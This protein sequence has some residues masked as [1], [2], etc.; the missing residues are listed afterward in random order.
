MTTSSARTRKPLLEDQRKLEW[1]IDACMPAVIF[2]CSFL[3]GKDY[4]PVVFLLQGLAVLLAIMTAHTAFFR[5]VRRV[6]L[7]AARHQLVLTD[8][9]HARPGTQRTIAIADVDRVYAVPLNCQHTGNEKW[10]LRLDLKSGGVVALG[11][12]SMRDTSEIA[13]VIGQFGQLLGVPQATAGL[14]A[15]SRADRRARIV[16]P[17]DDPFHPQSL[18]EAAG[19]MADAIGNTVTRPARQPRLARAV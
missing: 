2:A 18:T 9:F 13:A 10:R 12:T 8:R 16:A 1:A 11:F 19:R 7:D 3:F 14:P 15:K 6:E 5:P 17:A 4:W